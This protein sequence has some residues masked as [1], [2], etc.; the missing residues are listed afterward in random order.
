MKYCPKC[1]AVLKEEG[2]CHSCPACGGVWF[3]GGE[4]A[5]YFGLDV[6]RVNVEPMPEMDNKLIQHLGQVSCPDC[7]RR[8]VHLEIDGELVIERCEQCKG[9]FLDAGESLQLQAKLA[10]GFGDPTFRRVVCAALGL[11]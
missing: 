5:T 7:G 1:H 8:M 9:S 2:L 6:D 3:G 4:A 10:A 11:G